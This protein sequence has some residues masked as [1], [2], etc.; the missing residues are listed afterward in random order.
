MAP[1]SEKEKIQKKLEKKERFHATS[2]YKSYALCRDFSLRVW[3]KVAFQDKTI[4][5]SPA[6]DGSMIRTIRK[7]RPLFIYLS[8]TLLLVLF[9]VC[10][11]PLKGTVVFH[12]D[13]LGKA[14]A[15][16]FTPNQYRTVDAQGWFAYSWSKFTTSFW[17]LFELCFIGTFIGSLV[18]IPIYYLCARNVTR[19]PWIHMP[20]RIFND[21]LRTIPMFLICIFINQFFGTGNTI[22]AV[23]SIAFFT[24]SIM[25]QMMYEYIETL[26]MSPFEAIRSA[27]GSA[28]QCVHLGL[29]PE[30]KPMFFAYVIY[31][32]EIN[33]RASIILQYVGFQG[34]V[35]DLVDNI[36]N[37]WYDKAGA[38]LLPLFLVVAVLQF[39]SNTLARKLR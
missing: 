18:S 7:K 9:I 10:L 37:M 13:R 22:C 12:W 35:A 28:L 15:G 36:T 14:I 4:D 27:G 30:V 38:M 24:T 3:D 33:I 20:F 23:L 39:T 5:L 29:H 31:T 16:L 26:E 21:L 17:M 6:Q 25:Y 32:L 34:Y 2:F 8:L 1:L 11:I 19:S